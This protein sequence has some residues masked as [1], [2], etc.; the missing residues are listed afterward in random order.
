V[1]HPKRVSPHVA[2]SVGLAALWAI[3]LGAI[4]IYRHDDFATHGYDLGIFDQTIWGY[5]HFVVIPNTV[6]RVPD[7][8]GDHFHPILVSLAAMLAALAVAPWRGVTLLFDRWEK[9]RTLLWTFGSWA[10]LPL[11][12]PIALIGLPNIVERFWSTPHSRWSTSY[13]YALP[14]APVLAFAAIDGLRRVGSRTDARM[15][16]V[17][18]PAVAL[19]AVAATLVIAPFYTRAGLS[20]PEAAAAEACLDVIPS[21]TSVAASDLFVPHLSHRDRIYVLVPR[22]DDQQY[23]AVARRTWNGRRALAAIA[24]G[25]VRYATACRNSVITVLRRT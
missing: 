8:L 7:L 1:P 10:F 13:Q 5:S 11:L 15:I 21:G 23:V 16:R 6:K 22:T 9:V 17:G 4:S 12:S 3:A 20:G 24:R 19:C 18:A 14:L 25:H 2:A